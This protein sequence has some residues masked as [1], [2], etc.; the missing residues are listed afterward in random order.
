MTS[1]AEVSTRTG[2]YVKARE[3]ER[4]CGIGRRTLFKWAHAGQIQY[5]R[6][7]GRGH[8]L[9]DVSSVAPQPASTTRETVSAIYARVSTRKQQP[10]LHTQIKTLRTK[11]PDHQVFSDCASGLNFK[12]KGLQSLLQLAFEGRLRV[13]RIAHRDRLCRFAYDLVEFVLRKHGAKICVESD[14]SGPPS[15]ERELAEDVISVVTVFGARLY[16]ARSA[17][18]KKKNKDS[19]T[20]SH[21]HS[22]GA[23]GA[24]A[25][26][27]A[28]PEEGD[29]LGWADADLQGVDASYL[30]ATGG[31]EAVLCSGKAGVQ[32]RKRTK[33]GE[34]IPGPA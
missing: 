11:Y 33:K 30:G 7:G 8:W 32:S 5:L 9:F 18:R 31:A 29:P 21:K 12:R 2:R 27:E 28:V 24:E 23:G 14:D 6:P 3:A 22:G 10:D 26:A 16:G 17:G 34:S 4:I 19:E 13:V 25:Q 20:T 1:T 15:L